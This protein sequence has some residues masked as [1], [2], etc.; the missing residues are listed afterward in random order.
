MSDDERQRRV[1]AYRDY[2]KSQGL[3]RLPELGP[4]PGSNDAADSD[5]PYR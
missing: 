5:E 1:T 4:E 2:L 3:T